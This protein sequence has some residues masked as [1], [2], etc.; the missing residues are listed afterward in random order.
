MGIAL[1]VSCLANPMNARAQGQRWYG[2]ATWYYADTNLGSHTDMLVSSGS[3]YDWSSGGFVEQTLW[4]GTNND[5]TLNYWVEVGYTYG[6][7]NQNILTF[8]WADNRP[9]GGG[10]NEHQITDITPPL[11]TSYDMQIYWYHT[12]WLVVLNGVYDEGASTNN[13][14]SGKALA[15]GVESTS[16]AS[17]MSGADSNS[18]SYD[19]SGSGWVSGWGSGTTLRQDSPAWAYWTL[20]DVNLTDG[21]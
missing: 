12:E 21:I 7:K 17:S 15:T 6:W 1:A 3:C 14:A 16:S 13:P 2:A 19:K 4:Q 11:W 9:S 10:Y 5:P 18:L 20:T 8:Y